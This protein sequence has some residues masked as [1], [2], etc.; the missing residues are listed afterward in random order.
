MGT[1]QLTCGRGSVP[2]QHFLPC[3]LQCYVASAGNHPLAPPPGVQYQ[4]NVPVS[5]AYMARNHANSIQAVLGTAQ[6]GKTE[7]FL[8]NLAHDC[9]CASLTTLFMP[10]LCINL[11]KIVIIVAINVSFIFSCFSLCNICMMSQNS[12][13]LMCI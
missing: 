9:Q 8:I 13:Y 4:Q 10:L 12:V 3:V 6:L 5:L 7:G 11:Y 1:S 2:L